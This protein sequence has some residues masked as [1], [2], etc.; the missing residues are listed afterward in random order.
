MSK[1]PTLYSLGLMR[2]VASLMVVVFHFNNM[3]TKEYGESIFGPMAD[4]GIIGVDYFFVLSGFLLYQIHRKDWGKPA[5]AAHYAAKRVARIVPLYWVALIATIALSQLSSEPRM[6]VGLDWFYEFALIEPEQKRMIGVAWTLNLDMIYYIVFCF[7]ILLPI[8]AGRTIMI[9]W[10]S[11]IVVSNV[12]LGKQYGVAGSYALLFISGCF[13]SYVFS[14]LRNIQFS[15]VFLLVVG[16]LG[17]GVLI[18]M[19]YY[20]RL[21]E[22]FQL[23]EKMVVSAGFFFMLGALLIWERQRGEGFMSSRLVV[24]LADATYSIYLFH[25]MMGI[26]MFKVVMVTG[27]DSFVDKRVLLASMV[28]LAAIG[29]VAIHKVIERPLMKAIKP[30]VDKFDS[31]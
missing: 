15:R 11:L 22:V 26:I 29:G 17:L 31:K 21:Q 9:S 30:I 28:V 3:L 7:T 12:M 24:T 4:Y 6:P 1:N 16:A 2:V 10:V 5:L 8:W 20:N 18:G 13:L 19:E 25:I 14:L 23:Y 27:L